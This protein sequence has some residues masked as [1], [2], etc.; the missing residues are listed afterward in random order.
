LAST[1][2]GH[3]SAQCHPYRRHR[4]FPGQALGG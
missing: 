1:K 3:T 2:L 4:I